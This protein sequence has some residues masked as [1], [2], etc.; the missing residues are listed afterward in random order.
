M[1]ATA[2]VFWAC[3]LLVVYTYVGYGALLAVLVKLRDAVCP[4]AKHAARPKT[5][6]VTLLIAA[7]N[8]QDRRRQNG[9]LP[10]AGLPRRGRSTSP[11]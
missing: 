2:I 4:A 6:E 8:E 10:G 11:G 9:K 3:A 5:P 7:Y 1:T